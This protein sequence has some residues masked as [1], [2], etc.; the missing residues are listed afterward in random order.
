[1]SSDEKDK[2]ALTEKEMSAFMSGSLAADEQD[3]L[4]NDEHK[5]AEVADLILMDALLQETAV[6]FNCASPD[7]LLN[8]ET[9]ML[10]TEDTKTWVSHIENCTH[11]QQEIKQLQQIE[12]ISFTQSKTGSWLDTL[13]VAGRELLWALEISISQPQ[14]VLRG[15]ITKS[16]SY[17]VGPYQIVL[18]VEAIPGE[19]EYVQLEGQ[20]LQEEMPVDL[21]AVS[22]NLYSKNEIVAEGK[23]DPF[24]MFSLNMLKPGQFTL[25]IQLP[26][27]KSLIIE[28]IHIK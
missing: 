28:T 7:I 3:A 16:W 23:G 25:H 20:L 22:I 11:C 26:N 4:L 27:N 12:D 2:N 1:M 9:G 19:D 5:R 17:A 14:L 8:F 18:A 10:S 24:G 6:R 13:Q 15:E 21:T